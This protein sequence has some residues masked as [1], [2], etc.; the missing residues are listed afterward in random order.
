MLL[1]VSITLSKEN[2][3]GTYEEYQNAHQMIATLTAN[4]LNS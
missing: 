2:Y 4:E 3:I 1:T